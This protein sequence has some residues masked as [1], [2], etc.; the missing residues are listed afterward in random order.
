MTVL[1]TFAYGFIAFGPIAAL[2]IVTVV[3]QAHE[4]IIVMSR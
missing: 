3:R 4:I 1:A 2:F